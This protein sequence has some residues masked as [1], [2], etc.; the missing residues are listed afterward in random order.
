MDRET[1][2]CLARQI[3]GLPQPPHSDEEAFAVWVPQLS[4]FVSE[5]GRTPDAHSEDAYEARLGSWVNAQR[6]ADH[7]GAL[8]EKGAAQLEGILGPGWS[9]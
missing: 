9:S 6:A 4:A 7:H 3:T 2:R 5:Y 8:S 1:Q